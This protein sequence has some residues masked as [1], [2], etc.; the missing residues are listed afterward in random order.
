MTGSSLGIFKFGVGLLKPGFVVTSG[1]G[2]AKSVFSSGGDA[3][4]KFDAGLGNPSY[5]GL[6]TKTFYISYWFKSSATDIQVHWN[7]SNATNASRNFLG[8]NATGEF[9]VNLVNGAAGVILDVD[10]GPTTYND[11]LWHHVAFWCDMTS[12]SLRGLYIDDVDTVPTWNTYTDDF[13]GM[14]FRYANIFNRFDGFYQNGDL[15]LAEVAVDTRN[16]LDLGITANRRLFINSS[17]GPELDRASWPATLDH[18]N[19]ADDTESVSDFIT[20]VGTAASSGFETEDT[21]G[22]A[23]AIA[24]GPVTA[25]V[26]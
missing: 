12:T 23:L 8:L 9:F 20:N 1:S 21:A 16:F 15:Y 24:N 18:E 7:H 19:F 26:A 10:T 6:T 4:A 22:A 5:P 11:G 25:G 2:G 13:L 3:W 14:G 17:L